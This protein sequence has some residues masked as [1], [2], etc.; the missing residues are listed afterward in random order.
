M[1]TR[2]V[3]DAFGSNIGAVIWIGVLVSWFS[4]YNIEHGYSLNWDIIGLLVFTILYFIY[5]YL[6][7]IHRVK[8][9]F[10]LSK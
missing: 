8:G 7:T 1:K 6:Y 3:M 9:A 10:L 4:P 5:C 2:S